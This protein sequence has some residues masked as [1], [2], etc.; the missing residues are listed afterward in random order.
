LR[1]PSLT[2]NQ[3]EIRPDS[4]E[5]FRPPEGDIHLQRVFEQEN[6]EQRRAPHDIEVGHCAVMAVEKLGPFS[7]HSLVGSVRLKAES[8]IDVGPAVQC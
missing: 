2:E 7:H 8:E 4:G 1:R 6:A 3:P 5:V